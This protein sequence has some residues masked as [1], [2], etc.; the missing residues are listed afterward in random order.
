MR[1]FLK[2]QLKKYRC[3]SFNKGPP[4]NNSLVEHYVVGWFIIYLAKFIMFHQPRFPWNK[5]ISLTKPPF[6][7]TS[8]KVVINCPD[9]SMLPIT[10]FPRHPILLWSTI[11]AYKP[12]FQDVLIKTCGGGNNLGAPL[13][14][15][16]NVAP[17]SL[18]SICQVSKLKMA[19]GN[20]FHEEEGHQKPEDSRF[21]VLI[22]RN[23]FEP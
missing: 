2:S 16:R 17:K 4:K 21:F 23:S 15:S 18:R 14:L 12:R 9:I 13:L 10:W 3:I 1:F 7:V 5:G 8:A 19:F 11:R 20:Q 6:G 22:Q